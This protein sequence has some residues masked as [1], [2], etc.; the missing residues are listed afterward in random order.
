MEQVYFIC[1]SCG[2][3]FP[4]GKESLCPKCGGILTVAYEREYLREAGRALK[5]EGNESMWDYR[6]VLPPVKKE[7][8][9]TFQEGCTKIKKSRTLGEELGLEGLFF[10]DETTNPTGS[11]KDRSVSVCVSMAK[12]YGCPG[13]VVSSSGN[14]G[15]AT[16]AYGTKGEIDTIIFVPETTPVGKVAQAIAYGGKVIKVRGNFSCSYRAAVQMAQ[17]KGYMNVTTT[18]L[19]PFGLEGYKIIGYEIFDQ[20]G[21]VPDYIVIPVGAGPVL[22]GIYKSFAEMKDM[23]CTE[24]LPRL[25]CVQAKGCAPISEAWQ[26]NR[27]VIGCKNPRSVASAISDP[28]LGY[29][30]DGDIT[31]EAIRKTCGYGLTAEDSEILEAGRALAQKE[32]IFVEPS[33]AATVAAVRQMKEQGILKQGDTCV[34]LLTGHGLKD[35]SAYIPEGLEI[36]VINTIEDLS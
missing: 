28:L 20:M 16:G 34:C 7:N 29:E 26:E 15:A 8:I 3:R 32:G 31:V 6:R 12:E 13:I 14:G 1:H 4:M 2:E 23:G 36:P 25:V 11:F 35:S 21:E 9:V 22:Y 30:Q 27:R 17:E 24:K 10:K 33:S 19:S 5:G 18:F